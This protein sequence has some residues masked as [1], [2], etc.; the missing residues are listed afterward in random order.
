MPRGRALTIR[1]V[2]LDSPLDLRGKGMVVMKFDV[3]TGPLQAHGSNWGNTMLGVD[4]AN[5]NGS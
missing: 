5:V 1:S 3:S 2:D 4:V